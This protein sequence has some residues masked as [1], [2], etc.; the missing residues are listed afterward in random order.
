MSQFKKGQTVYC[1]AF[2]NGVV[3]T[4]DKDSTHPVVIDF[5]SGETFSYT[6]DGKLNVNGPVC[7]YHA[8]P[9]I[10]V[11]KWQ[12]KPVEWCWFW[13][14]EFEGCYFRRFKKMV[15]GEYRD[16]TSASWKNC[17]PFKGELPE[18]LKEVQP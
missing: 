6:M 12:P 5:P 1:L 8:K 9:E 11:P 14:E 16:T 15:N 18:H 2:G 3:Y 4:I 10:I 17:A 7:L 13:D